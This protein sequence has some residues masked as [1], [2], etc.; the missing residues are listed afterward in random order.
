MEG[1]K[2]DFGSDT[3]KLRFYA[4]L[5]EKPEGQKLIRERD[6]YIRLGKYAEALE[7]SKKIEKV[8]SKAFS[9]YVKEAEEKARKIN[10]LQL[11]LPHEVVMKLN[12]LYITAFMTADI[13][14]SCIM[15]MDN[16]VR[17]YDS[18]MSVKMFDE[19]GRQTRRP[20]VYLGCSGKLRTLPIFPSGAMSATICIK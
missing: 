2:L 15:D 14:E 3:L 7:V 6:E 5:A 11:G 16:M 17:K 1:Y 18:T 12:V 20:R 4:M 10:I 19:L 8:M 9:Y 13:L